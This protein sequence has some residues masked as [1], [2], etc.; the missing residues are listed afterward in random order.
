M[1][2]SGIYRNRAVNIPCLVSCAVSVIIGGI[3]SAVIPMSSISRAAQLSRKEDMTYK[4]TDDNQAAI[5][6]ALRD[7]GA[8][9]ESLASIGGGCPDLL[10]SYYD[11]M[12]LMEVKAWFYGRLTKPQRAWIAKWKARVHIVRNVEQALAVIGIESGANTKG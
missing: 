6:K 3:E 9:V 2:P 7:A 12:Y 5:V 4:R 10:V 8:G 1:R 11:G